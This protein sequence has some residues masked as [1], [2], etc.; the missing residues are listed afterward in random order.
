M[1]NK[2][3]WIRSARFAEANEL[4]NVATQDTKVQ[5]GGATNDAFNELTISKVQK[6][7]DPTDTAR[8]AVVTYEIKVGNDGTDPVTGVK[9]RDTLPAGARYIE[10]TGTN[11]FLCTQAV[12][13]VVDRIGGQIPDHTPTA[14]GATITITVFAPDT[15]GLYTNQVEVDPDYAIVEGNEFDNNASATTKVN[16][17]GAGSFND[18]TIAKTGPSNVTPNAL[19]TYTLVVSNDGSDPALNV[20]V[21]DVLPMGETFVSAADAGAGPGAS[22]T[23]SHSGLTVDCIGATINNGG[24]GAA[25]TITIVAKAPNLTIPSPGL[26]NVATVDPTTRFRKATSSTT[27]PSPTRRSRRTTT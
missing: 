11:S 18:L 21:R 27:A 15:P 16:N 17:G 20:A 6:T 19:I 24:V 23:C 8:N 22:F 4:N 25:R 2:S 12:A 1:H 7:P 14:S 13:G 3:E 9:V 26:H 10:A 5:R